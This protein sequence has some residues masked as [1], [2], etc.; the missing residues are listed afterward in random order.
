MAYNPAYNK[1]T[2]SA[3]ELVTST[4]LNQMVDNTD[5]NYKYKP[6]LGPNAPTTNPLR[7]ARGTKRITFGSSEG[8]KAVTVTFSTEAEDGNPGFANTPKIVCNLADMQ[9]EAGAPALDEICAVDKTNT[10]FKIYI[11][12]GSGTGAYWYDV[13]WIA[14]GN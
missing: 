4:K 2:W 7:L 8:S 6:E 5:H 11:N 3:E 9:E 12:R 13:D 1:S 10:T 14:V